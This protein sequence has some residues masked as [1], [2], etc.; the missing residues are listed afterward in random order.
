MMW[1]GY[2]SQHQESPGEI[3]PYL[4]V[5]KLSVQHN[6]TSLQDNQDE[7]LTISTLVLCP[8][9]WKS[10]IVKGTFCQPVLMLC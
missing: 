1:L 4:W 3:L 8:N 7:Q 2:I 6:L 5:P 9:N 10:H